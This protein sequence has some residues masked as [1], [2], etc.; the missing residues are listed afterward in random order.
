M[1]ILGSG[2]RLAVVNSRRRRLHEW[3]RGGCLS[4]A[5]ANLLILEFET[6]VAKSRGIGTSEN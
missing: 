4:M 6:D 1:R 3:Q 5:L 2:P